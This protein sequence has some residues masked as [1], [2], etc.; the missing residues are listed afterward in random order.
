MPQPAYTTLTPTGAF[1]FQMVIPRALRAPGG[2]I[3]VRRTLPT[4]NRRVAER[5][6]GVIARGCHALFQSALDTGSPTL[7]DIPGRMHAL[8]DDVLRPVPA[9]AFVA[10]GTDSCSHV[11]LFNTAPVAPDLL[12]RAQRRADALLT[13][14]ARPYHGRRSA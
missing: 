14:P 13:G 1:T 3:S 4:S 6:S 2:S 9:A 8:A 7:A 11:L 12:A 5:L 10:S